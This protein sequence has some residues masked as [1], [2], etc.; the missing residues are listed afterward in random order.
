MYSIT[1]SRKILYMHPNINKMELIG[2]RIQLSGP[3]NGLIGLHTNSNFPSIWAIISLTLG[4]KMDITFS[5]ILAFNCEGDL[6]K[7]EE[8]ENIL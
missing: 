8:K 7:N 6:R 5:K 3:Y 1:L 4:K 2:A